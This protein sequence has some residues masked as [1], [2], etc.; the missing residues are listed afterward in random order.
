MLIP[1]P[2]RGLLRLVDKGRVGRCGG[3]GARAHAVRR[4]LCTRGRGA[5]G[6]SPGRAAVALS[7]LVEEVGRRGGLVDLDRDRG[8]SPA[9]WVGA[10]A[11]AGPRVGLSSRCRCRCGCWRSWCRGWGWGWGGGRGRRGCGARCELLVEGRAAKGVVEPGRGP[12][13]RLLRERVEEDALSR[14]GSS[15]RGWREVRDRGRTRRRDQGRRIGP[16]RRQGRV[17]RRSFRPACC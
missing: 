1:L 15:P 9:L 5:E 8:G 12:T 16:R 14:W 6:R 11:G 10:G 2:L 17:C 4:A 13:A 7:L 3:D